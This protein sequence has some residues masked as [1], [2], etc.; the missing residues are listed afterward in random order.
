MFAKGIE[1]GGEQ[2]ENVLRLIENIF[3]GR[4]DKSAEDFRPSCGFCQMVC[5]GQDSNKTKE[6]YKLIVNSGYI[7]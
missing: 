6:N 1:K 5:S 4:N 2:A 7:D 3:L